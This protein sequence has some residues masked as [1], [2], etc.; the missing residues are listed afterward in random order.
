[1]NRLKSL[2]IKISAVLAIILLVVIALLFTIQ[3]HNKPLDGDRVVLVDSKNGNYL[4]RGNNPVVEK[5]DTSFFAYEE[6]TS[7]FNKELKKNNHPT[8]SDYHLVDI[9][10]LDLDQIRAILDEKNF[11]EKNPNLGEFHNFSLLSLYLPMQY[12]PASNSVL[13]FVKSNYENWLSAELNKIHQ[14]LSANSDKPIVIYVHCD[15]GRDR[16]GMLIAAYKMKFKNTSLEQARQENIAEV[17]R[18]TRPIYNNGLRSYC[19]T[20]KDEMQKGE[21]FCN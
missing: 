12:F 18:N 10:L 19:L 6:L 17:N 5:N 1:M 3:R 9:S 11:F 4:F 7:H 16:T 8:L 20:I 14:Q 13:P 2:F 21:D 15:A